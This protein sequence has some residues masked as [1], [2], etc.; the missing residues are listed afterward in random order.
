MK[1]RK[2]MKFKVYVTD[3]HQVIYTKAIT[4]WLKKRRDYLIRGGI[5]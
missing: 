1:I 3:L 4:K 2:R 5:N